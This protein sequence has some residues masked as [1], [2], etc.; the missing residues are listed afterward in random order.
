[1]RG[2]C[3]FEPIAD[4]RGFWRC[5]LCRWENKRPLDRPP[6][7]NCPLAPTRPQRPSGQ[8]SAD[9]VQRLL[10]SYR[11]DCDRFLPNEVCADAPGCKRS[12]DAWRRRVADYRWS[13]PLG[14]WPRPLPIGEMTA[15]ITAWRRPDSLARLLASIE[16]FYPDLRVD[17]ED[18][19][20]NLS[21]G[22]NRLAARCKTD[23]CVILEDDFEF[24]A[25]GDPLA[26]LQGVLAAD[27]E[28]GVA[29][30]NL[31][32]NGRV[33]GYNSDLR[34]FRGA[35][36]RRP[37]AD[38]WRQT[39]QGV[40]YRYVD[41]G[42]NWFCARVET[43]RGLPWDEQLELAEH[44]AWFL[45]LQR[46]GLWRVAHV[47]A[48]LIA[49][50]K[51][52]PTA[53][54]A[55]ARKRANHYSATLRKR[56][57]F[58]RVR[59]LPPPAI[60]PRQ[61]GRTFATPELRRL[62]REAAVDF[63]RE[64]AGVFPIC[65]TLL[66]AVRGGD[67]IEHDSDVD[68]GCL[69][70]P[71]AALRP[72]VFALIKRYH[73]NGQLVELVYRHPNGV[74]VDLFLFLREQAERLFV[75]YGDEFAN[76]PAVVRRFPAEIVERLERRELWGHTFTFLAEPEQFLAANYGPGWKTPDPK[77]QYGGLQQ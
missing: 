25:G 1:M 5:A 58:D 56:H 36:E 76:R 77:W 35:L 13:C 21:A 43:L 39:P 47:P 18:T 28:V 48:A 38:Q 30:G 34:V 42:W 11:G 69:D 41:L 74:K 71:A 75:I 52:R 24:T 57:G 23:L 27:S 45:Q 44:A 7:R 32:M 68:F 6:R 16:R 54:Y 14:K 37:P 53:E 3:A 63:A 59:E 46:Q 8:R 66:G 29:C 61:N 9:Q 72:T 65:G 15:C 50:H 60:R 73:H 70:W 51:D 33:R 40:L 20:G 31:L 67:V 62:A 49:H 4:R 2:Q 10:E 55:A 64:F 22:R 26:A 17:V 19:G 12:G